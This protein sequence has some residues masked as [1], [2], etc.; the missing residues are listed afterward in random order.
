[1]G[2]TDSYIIELAVKNRFYKWSSETK[3]YLNRAQLQDLEASILYER[4]QE[5][6]KSRVCS[7]KSLNPRGP[8]TVEDAR[9]KIRVKE[10]KEKNKAIRRAEKAIKDSIK[11][12]QNILNRQ[13]I[14]ARKAEREIRRLYRLWK[15]EE[16]SYRSSYWPL[17]ETL[18]R[19]LQQ[20]NLSLYSRIRRSH[21]PSTN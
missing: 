17:F 8:I 7:R 1:M 3:I 4:L 12:A 9:E 15:V 6:Q 13:G 2:G 21:K 5:S 11:Q 16:S 10:L 20:R 19:T 18:R 14:D